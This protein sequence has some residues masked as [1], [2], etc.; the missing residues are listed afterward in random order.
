MNLRK[1]LSFSELITAFGKVERVPFF[2]GTERCETDIEH[3]YQLAMLAWYL[4]SS[5]KLDLNLSKILQLALAHDLVEVHAGDTYVYS[6]DT[7]HLESKKE[8]ET[9]AAKKLA[10]DFPEL[11]DVHSAIAEY[12]QRESREARFVYALDKIL[13]LIVNYEGNGIGWKKHGVTLQ[14][15]IDKKTTQVALSPEIE[16]YFND[17]IALLRENEGKLFPAQP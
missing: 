16:P 12:E 17:L 3:S 9:A 6:T 1:L 8:R 2:P 10:E 15:L 13:P 7:A 11:H 4:V 5:T 14:M